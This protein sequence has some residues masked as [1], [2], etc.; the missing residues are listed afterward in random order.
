MKLPS[1]NLG[2]I[3]A[4][5]IGI[6]GLAYG[7]TMMV[8]EKAVYK[9]NKFGS[10]GDNIP[11]SGPVI[12]V[13][14]K[15]GKKYTTISNDN[16]NLT[17]AS[18]VGGICGKRSHDFKSASVSVAGTSHGVSGTGKHSMKTHTESF[19]FPFTLPNMPRTPAAA[20]NLELDKRVANSD[21]S[22]NYFMSRGF[23]V[24]YQN[25]YEAKFTAACSG[26]LSKGSFDS[27]TIKTPVWIACASTSSGSKPNSRPNKPPP[28]PKPSPVPLKVTAKLDATQQGTIYAEKCPASVRYTGSIYVSKPNTKVTYQILSTE[29]DSPKRTITIA[30]PGSQE[31]TGWSQSY[32]E[33]KAD[34]N[35]LSSGSS[36]AR[37]TPDA[38]GSVR[39]KVQYEGGTA[40]S[41][42]IPYTVFCNMEKPKSMMIKKID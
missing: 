1:R 38:S 42:A 22:R 25:A 31:I 33:K 7:A 29:W 2:I 23:V 34:I 35:S 13:F 19:Q 24:K 12:H 26:G 21:K 5:C 37:K 27:K 39:L 15:D 6:S 28:R 10:S 14:S 11:I 17:H 8:H 3:V 41:A 4:V 32:R 40:Q 30:K 36:N 20:C 18:K 9:M 16:E